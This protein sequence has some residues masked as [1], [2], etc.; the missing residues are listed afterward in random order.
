MNKTLVAISRNG[1]LR[2]FFRGLRFHRLYNRWL[3]RWP[4]KKTLPK[5]GITYRC[6]RT[7]SVSLALE[8]LEGGNCYDGKYLPKDFVT[9][10]DI[11]CNV[12]FFMCWLA[13]QAGDRSISGVMI[14]ANPRVVEESQWHVASNKLDG[15][16]VVHGLIGVDQQDGNAAFYLCE[17]DTCSTAVLTDLHLQNERMFSKI[18]A[19]VVSFE[20]EWHQRMGDQRCNILKIDVEGAEMGFLKSNSTFLQLV[21]SIYIEWHKYAVSF[22]DLT[23]FLKERGFELLRIVEDEGFN[24]VAVYHRLAGT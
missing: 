12:G 4:R 22:D 14:D 16:H 17:A 20:S 7:E 1:I 11:G 2:R 15:I 23:H 19:P 3:A 6:C 9:F 21:D 18:D 8:I 24:G 10:A 5:S 13:E